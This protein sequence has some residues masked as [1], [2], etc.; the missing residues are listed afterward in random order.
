MEAP[1]NL[2]LKSADY[3]WYVHFPMKLTGYVRNWR[4][5]FRS[6][7]GLVGPPEKPNTAS[8]DSFGYKWMN[9]PEW[10]QFYKKRLNIF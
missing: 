3:K 7:V 1:E 6:L 10:N 4:L 2:R 8:W 9:E 5:E